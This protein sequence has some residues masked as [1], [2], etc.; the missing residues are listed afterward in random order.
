MANRDTAIAE[1]YW[2]DTMYDTVA[3]LGRGTGQEGS[4]DEPA[5]FKSY[6]GR[7]GYRLPQRLPRTLG[8][9]GAAL[10]A[11]TAR[12]ADLGD[13]AELGTLLYYGYGLSRVDVGPVAGWPYHRTVPSARCF[14]PTE[15][16]LVVG[17][18]Q[19]VPAGVYHY[20]Q[21]HHRLVEL[22]RGD[23]RG[24]LAAATGRAGT[25]A[26][27]LAV[28]TSH[29]WKT[30]FRYRHYAYRLCSQEAGMVVGNLQM[31]AAA[32]GVPARVHYQF[33]DAAVD[34]LLGLPAGEERAMAVLAFGA[35]GSGG[36]G[37]GATDGP[38]WTGHVDDLVAALPA[39]HAPSRT[40]AADLSLASS[41]YELDANSVLTDSADLVARWPEPAPAPAAS[42]AGEVL[43]SELVHALRSRHSGGTLF[44]PSGE[45]MPVEALTA[46]L[47]QA[48]R[49]YVGDLGAAPHSAVYALAQRVDGLDPGAY[50]SER[51]ALRHVDGLPEGRLDRQVING[52]AVVDLT[53][54]NAVAYV[55]TDRKLATDVLGNRGY[56]IANMD[57]GVV[58]QRLCVLAAAAGL[59][60]RPFNGYLTDAVQRLL[61]LEETAT[62]MF[63]IAFGRR[64][65]S[66]QYEMPIVF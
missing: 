41:A 56:R 20:D 61:H 3:V 6:P 14:Y 35:P 49:P 60:A 21:A 38:R 17:P 51:A 29:F 12:R 7:A 4:A 19:Q 59:A 54:T 42:E 52:P 58:G 39:V 5:K 34:H 65:P 30:A 64:V 9:V 37:S 46:V 55:V 62:P 63:Q 16:Y 13:A 10:G 43:S 36:P 31:T 11:D 2:H 33:L 25:D 40:V 50:R 1:T 66:A 28:A 57:A 44:R 8:T 47:T 26:P 27:V 23:H 15:L 24:H 48:A 32:M 45:P 18:D 22:R 53:S